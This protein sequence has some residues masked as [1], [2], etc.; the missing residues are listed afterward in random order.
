MAFG[1]NEVYLGNTNGTPSNGS[2]LYFNPPKDG[3]YNAIYLKFI[4]TDKSVMSAAD[5]ATCIGDIE[6]SLNGDQKIKFPAW[7]FQQIFTARTG[8]P[9]PAGLLPIMLANGKYEN[10]AQKEATSWGMTGVTQ[11]DLNVNIINVTNSTKTLASV[12][13]YADRTNASAPLGAHQCY[14]YQTDT[15]P[16]TGNYDNTTLAT[17]GGDARM[18]KIWVLH[19]TTEGRKAEFTAQRLTINGNDVVRNDLPEDVVALGNL[20]Y[21]DFSPTAK[22]TVFTFDGGDNIGMTLPMLG[23]TNLRYRCDVAGTATADIPVT[24]LMEYVRGVQTA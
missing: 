3:V 11:F 6:A 21:G 1:R 24:F 9:S 20:C 15:A 14:T 8:L 2:K 4:N 7:A 5:I 19:D 23:I 13:V 12:M 18:A 16:K 10:F 17:I 22:G